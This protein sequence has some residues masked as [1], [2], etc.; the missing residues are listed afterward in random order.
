MT[1][2]LDD[3]RSTARDLA[4]KRAA[5]IDAA[6]ALG[7]EADTSRADATAAAAVADEAGYTDA[8]SRV[9][10]LLDQ[11]RATLGQRA[12]LDADLAAAIAA[13]VD[14]P[15]DLEPD[16]PLALLPVRLETRY[17]ADGATL[18]VRIY[19]DDIHVDRLERGLTADERAAGTAYWQAVWNG[20]ASEADAWSWLLTAVGPRRA[21]WVAAALSPDLTTRPN[22]PVADATPTLPDPVAPRQLPPV[23]RALPDRFVVVAIQDGVVSRA[24]GNPVPDQ[25]VVGLAPTADP[26]S[27]VQ[28]NGDIN[29]GAGMEWL[30][31]PDAARQAG[32]LV[33]VRLA[34]PNAPVERVLAFGVRA[35]LAPADAAAELA[36][37]LR[38][39]RYTE[40]AAFVPVGTPT[41]NTET[42]R[43]DWSAAPVPLPPPTR[44][45]DSDA[46]ANASVAAAALGV[47][48]GAVTDWQHGD[49]RDQ[50]LWAAANTALWQPT[51]GCFV[52][53]V[54]SGMLPAP[55]ITD[56]V[57]ASWRDWWQADVRAS[58]PLPSVRIG[59]QPYGLLPVSSVQTAWQPDPN[60]PFEAELLAVLR[61]ARAPLAAG[62]G[63]VPHVGSGGALD[64]TLLD[65]LGSAPVSAGLRVRSIGS[66]ASVSALGSLYGFDVGASNQAAQDL[67]VDALCAQLGIAAGGLRGSI[68]KTTRPLGLPLVLDDGDQPGD[69]AFLAALRA[70]AD[71]TVNSVLQALLEIALAREHAAVDQAAP[72][73]QLGTLLESASGALGA[74][75]QRVAGLIEQVRAGAADPAELAGTAHVIAAQFG[76]IAQNDLA[77]LQPVAALRTNLADLA[78]TPG[79]PAD[80]VQQH[81]GATIGAWLAAQARL[82]QF[83]AAAQL[84]VE[85]PIGQRRLAVAGTLDCASH[86]YD[87]WVTSLAT[88]RLTSM[89]S[90]TPAGVLLGAYGWVENLTPGRSTTRNGG[91]LHAP[92]VVHAATAG[93]LRSGYLTHNQD[94]AGSGALAIDLTSARVRSAK[95]LLDGVRQGQPLGALLGY[96]IERAL[97]EAG[98]DVYTSSLRALAP[99]SAGRVIDPVD[100]LPAEG[101]ETVAANNVVDGVRLLAMP[102]EQ[103]WTKLATP[104]VNPYLDPSLWPDPAPHEPAL[105]AILDEA[106]AAYDAVSDVLTAEAVHQLVQGNT[107]RAAAAMSAAAGGDAPPV[108]ADVVRTP[109]RAVPVTHRVLLV[110]D[111]TAPGTGGWSASAPRAVAEPRIAAWVEQR[112]GPATTVVV[113]VGADGTRTTLDQAGLSA[114]D[115]VFDAAVLDDRLRSALPQLGTDPLAAQRDPAWPQE[116][117]PINAIVA[118]ASAL[119][120]FVSSAAVLAPE[121]FARAS[122]RPTR[123]ATSV[124]LTARL[125][126]LITQL[127][128]A[129]DALEHAL[130]HALGAA[131]VDPAAV[132]SANNALRAYGIALPASAALTEARR[133]VD[134]TTALAVPYDLADAQKAAS[135]LFGDGFVVLPDISTAP[136]LFHATLGKQ[137]PGRTAIRRW[138][139][140]LAAVRPALADYTATMLLGTGADQG[141]GR[142]LAIAQL[143]ATGT[144]GTAS[145]L[146]SPLA[147][148]SASP[149]APVTAVVVDAP[150]GYADTKAV[151]GLVVDEWVE[152]LPRHDA[153]GAA[154]LTTGVAVNAN[155]P[156]ARAPQ[157]VLVAVSPDGSRW[158]TDAL[159]GLL[160]EVRDLAGLRGV[161]L[162]RQLLPSPV[163]PAI[164]EQSWSLQGQPTFDLSVLST[165]IG[166]AEFM[167]A[168]VKEVDP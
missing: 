6:A 34:N 136:D 124:R 159:I 11:R 89:R 102:R 120:S 88:H 118:E 52:E 15:C 131:P 60:D 123:T 168:F 10:E 154:T 27:I 67:L 8:Q 74:Q 156:A 36:D 145:W 77:V 7:A 66:T 81:A 107:A 153:G 47:D 155:A 144:A 54:V 97:H 93:I 50:P 143:A 142:E 117:R 137:R 51:W 1:A 108:D 30:A 24:V 40:G 91:Y 149:N 134:A 161:T 2:S 165:E 127:S 26:S 56:A 73:P 35:S 71:R 17:S 12:A 5:L 126:P 16:V 167:P 59:D 78:A 28:A 46:A 44:P 139:R 106:A 166:R 121:S 119:R 69:R 33:E 39:H 80:F 38:A 62:L 79:L 158:T 135:V 114:L 87:A 53:R 76:T 61:N 129:A 98:L 148:G 109:T 63:E 152:Q 68:G 110:L 83:S 95:H 18:R 163:L 116:L 45:T 75:G 19:P 140:T 65:V 132:T 25:L 41:N 92:S 49:D 4:A 57:T 103:I 113:H 29:L 22:P 82:A 133:R 164:Q 70:G 37:L 31:D 42:D 23:A 43:S 100:G 115:V 99:V 147:A 101:R 151:G 146:G 130:E 111:D 55:S 86:R 72:Q 90:A 160:T 84:L 64:D 125:V 13:L 20:S 58:G 122:D 128:G 21:G 150:S 32:M 48:A 157:A 9:G 104:P 112:L 162:E 96:L 3:L 94:E 85:A 105:G 138:L 141:I 14:D